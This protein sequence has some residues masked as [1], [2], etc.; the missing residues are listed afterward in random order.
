MR[1]AWW[2]TIPKAFLVINVVMVFF[3][4]TTWLERKLLGRQ[5]AVTT[6]KGARRRFRRA[7]GFE[8]GN[9]LG[10]HAAFLGQGR[11]G[12]PFMRAAPSMW[13]LQLAL[14]W[15]ERKNSI[16]RIA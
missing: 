11:M 3:A 16:F 10:L 1:E 13:V 5:D 12:K 2:I 14:L 15:K 7:A 9:G 6:G 8:F 4:F